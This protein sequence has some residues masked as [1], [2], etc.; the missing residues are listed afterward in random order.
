MTPRDLVTTRFL[1]SVDVW[2]TIRQLSSRSNTRKAAVSYVSS[3]VLLKFGAGDLLVVDASDQ[4]VLGGQTS[5]SV[6]DR[7]F[8]RGA[9]IV[10]VPQLHAKVMLF[11]DTAVVGSVNISVRSAHI[12]TEAMVVT[13]QRPIVRSI[14]RWIDELLTA[15]Q[16]VDEEA[17]RHLL[18]LESQRAPIRRAYRELSE[19][20]T[21]FFKE[22]MVGDIAKYETLSSTAGT[23]GGARDLRVSPARV[24]RPTLSRMLAERGGRSGV[25]FGHVRS[26]VGTGRV[27]ETRVEL[28]SPTTA[29]PNELRIAR[30]YEVPGWHVT[31]EHLRRTRR[32]G[33]RL[34]YVLEMDIH[35][36]VTAKV[37]TDVQLSRANPIIGRHIEN[38][39]LGNRGRRSIV[40]AVDTTDNITAPTT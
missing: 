26:R 36:T 18:A 16:Q 33:H 21:V 3:D 25:T 15:G 17:L 37:M 40:G 39:A 22:V 19:T 35:G 30:F 9:R 10:S 4:S 34:F 11:G 7:A 23:G 24:F 5:A 31:R 32:R 28:W 12:L 20:D 27:Q 2:P 1:A 14:S 29:R 8:A 38:L 6:I 13:Q